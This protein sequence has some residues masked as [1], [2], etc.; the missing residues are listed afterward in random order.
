[1]IHEQKLIKKYKEEFDKIYINRPDKKGVGSS[2]YT[3]CFWLYAIVKE[4]DLTLIV[5]SGTW[6]GQS[7]WIMR[8]ADGTVPIMCFDVSFDNLR[9]RDPSTHNT[10]YGQYDWIKYTW[11]DMTH[12]N[13]IIFFDDHISQK[14]RLQEAYDRGFKQLIFDDNIPDIMVKIKKNPP[15]PT[16][17]QLYV[18][19]DPIIKL[20]KNYQILT[21][22]NDEPNTYLT[23]VEL[24]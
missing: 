12:V 24:I 19:R 5:E 14:Q 21:H 1:M 23:Y 17:Q 4:L 8:Q 6:K 22:F 18:S 7:S 15:S 13:C 2:R 10:F 20:I 11:T 16:L 9:W 3:N